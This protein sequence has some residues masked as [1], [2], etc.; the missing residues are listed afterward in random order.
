MVDNDKVPEN[1]R[2]KWAELVID[3]HS[4]RNRCSTATEGVECWALLGNWLVVKLP[5]GGSDKVILAH[6]ESE[7]EILG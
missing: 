2:K 4:W 3:R 6:V 5:L 7:S 1:V